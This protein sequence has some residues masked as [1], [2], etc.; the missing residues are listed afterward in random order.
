MKTKRILSV[1]PALI[2]GVVLSA[3]SFAAPIYVDPRDPPYNAA[4]DATTDDQTALS[5]ALT[6]AIS[7]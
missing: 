6:A 1:S 7:A 5:A 4:C 2:L 3:S